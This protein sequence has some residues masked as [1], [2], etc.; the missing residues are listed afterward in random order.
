MKKPMRR[1]MV[2]LLVA[3]LAVVG[4]FGG[5]CIYTI[6]T[7]YPAAPLV[8]YGLGVKQRLGI[9]SA[10]MENPALI[11]LDEPTNA[12]DE[13]GVVMVRELL[14]KQ[15]KNGAVIIVASHD[16]EELELLTD[17]ILIIENGKIKEHFDVQASLN[18]KEVRI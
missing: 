7:R 16:K 5:F 11:L 12:L 4:V 1:L 18:E 3:L 14:E 15:K 13:S 6:N 17:E 10:V 9:A 8:E 2:I